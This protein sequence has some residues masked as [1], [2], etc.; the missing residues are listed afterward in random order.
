MYNVARFENNINT[1]AK[2]ACGD[3]W[4]YHPRI[5][6]MNTRYVCTLTD[7]CTCTVVVYAGEVSSFLSVICIYRYHY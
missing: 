6:I 4:K 7:Q 5:P 3:F 1:P 2:N